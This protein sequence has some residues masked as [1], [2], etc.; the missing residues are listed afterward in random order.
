MELKLKPIHLESIAAALAKA[1]LYRNLNEP[2]EAESIC[3]DILAI[4]PNNQAALR[5]I[6]LAITDLFTG[7][8]SDRYEEVENFFRQLSDPY[9][10]IYCLGLLYERRAKAQMRVGRPT[11]TLVQLFEEAMR[12]FAEAEKIRPTDND[13][14]ILRWNRCVRLL[15]SL[16]RVEQ[17]DVLQFD[18]G[19]SPPV[20]TGA[21]VRRERAW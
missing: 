9:E 14:S 21:A 11:Q 18:A 13:E 17:A 10:Q 8:V 20:S 19:D 4:Q 1:E 6:G 12:H 16:P 7:D 15:E 3:H 5:L 2:E